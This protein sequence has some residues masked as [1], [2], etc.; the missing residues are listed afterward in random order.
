[1]IQDSNTYQRMVS[2][3]IRAFINDDSFKTPRGI[4]CPKSFKNEII[5]LLKLN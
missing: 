3:C 4:K 1:M 5:E 2:E